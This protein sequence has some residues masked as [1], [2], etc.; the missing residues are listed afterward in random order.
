MVLN[1]IG[2]SAAGDKQTLIRAA[3]AAGFWSWFL[4]H[5]DDVLLEKRVLKLVV[6]KI[7]V[8]DLRSLF[9]TL[10]GPQPSSVL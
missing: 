1:Q 6:I 10:F 7:R 5:Q 3:L 9:E 8:R 4:R 2:L